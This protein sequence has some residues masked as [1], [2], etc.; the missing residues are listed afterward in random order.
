MDHAS[1]TV[2]GRSLQIPKAW[3]RTRPFPNTL[4]MPSFLDMRDL[5]EA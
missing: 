5:E 1:S 4:F 3:V 2:P